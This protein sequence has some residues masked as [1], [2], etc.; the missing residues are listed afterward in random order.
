MSDERSDWRGKKR[1]SLPCR[2]FYTR[3]FPGKTPYEI[4]ATRPTREERRFLY[5]HFPCSLLIFYFVVARL[6]KVESVWFRYTT[7]TLSTRVWIHTRSLSLSPDIDS[8]ERRA[9]CQ[10]MPLTTLPIH[11]FEWVASHRRV[12]KRKSQLLVR[13][14]LLH[15]QYRSLRMRRIEQPKDYYYS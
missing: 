15:D 14:L 4:S 10:F 7:T 1:Q 3:L 13:Q 12:R 6:S 11:V 5:W 8:A 2:S 9:A